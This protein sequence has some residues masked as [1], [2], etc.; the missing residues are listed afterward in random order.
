MVDM[1]KV[2]TDV[3]LPDIQRAAASRRKY[4]IDSMPVGGSFLIPER[5][6]RSVSAYVSRI[7]SGT[8]KKF[9]TRKVWLIKNDGDWIETAEGAPGAVAGAG[10][11]R[12]Q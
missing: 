8:G 6:T 5:S 9:S 2:R 11:W 3:P 12:I 7:A 1:F 4:P 10:V